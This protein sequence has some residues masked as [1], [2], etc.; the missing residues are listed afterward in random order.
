MSYSYTGDGT[1]SYGSF[2]AGRTGPNGT[3]TISGGIYADF[4]TLYA[5]VPQSVAPTVGAI[6]FEDGFN[7]TIA[8]PTSYYALAQVGVNNPNGYGALNVLSGSRFYSFR[9]V[10]LFGPSNGVNLLVGAGEDSTGQVTVDGNNAFFVASGVDSLVTIGR[11]GGDGTLTMSNNAIFQSFDLVVGSGSGPE[12]TTGLVEIQ[13]G[14]TIRLTDVDGRS[15]QFNNVNAG[16]SAVIGND[17]SGTG[18]LNI[19]GGGS[20]IIENANS[21]T[22][23]PRLSL[24]QNF[25]PSDAGTARGTATVAGEGSEIRLAQYGR[26][27]FSY[28]G[29]QP[30]FVVGD[31]GVGELT[32]SDNAQVNILGDGAQLVVA[33]G[34]PDSISEASSV[35]IQSGA[36][37]TVDSQN[38]GFEPGYY[39]SGG[40]SVTIAEAPGLDGLIEVTGEGSLLRVLGPDL[41]SDFSGGQISVGLVGNGQLTVSNGGAVE[42][43]MLN[44][45]Q[46]AAQLSLD[47]SY[48]N[49]LS[50]YQSSLFDNDPT[51]DPLVSSGEVLISSGG[52]VTLTATPARSYRGLNLAQVSGSEATVTVT[53]AGSTLTSTGGAGFGVIGDYGTGVLN[54]ED[55]GQVF[56]RNLVVSDRFGADGTLNVDGAGSRLVLS[57][58]FTDNVGFSTN[59]RLAIGQGEGSTGNVTVTNGGRIEISSDEE[60]IAPQLLVG[61]N[62]TGTLLIDGA[63]PDSGAASTVTLQQQGP[64]GYSYS[65]PEVIIGGFGF[66]DAASGTA[67]VQNG[68]QLTVYGASAELRIESSAGLQ[69]E[70]QILSGGDVLIDS[71]NYGYASAVVA[72]TQDSY[73]RILVD[74]EGSTLTVRSDTN[75]PGDYTTGQ[76]VLGASEGAVGVL[77]V[78]NGGAVNLTQ[79]NIGANFTGYLEGGIGRVTVSDGGSI[80]TTTKSETLYRGVQVG[81]NAGSRGFLTIDGAGSVVTSTG[82]PNPIGSDDGFP[83]D[84]VEGTGRVQIGDQGYGLSEVVNGG[85]LNGFFVE[86]GRR[87][88][89]EGRLVIDGSGSTLNVSNAYGQFDP[90]NYDPVGGFLRV[91]RDGGY[92]RVDVTNGGLVNVVNLPGSGADEPGVQIGRNVATNAVFNV[93]GTDG[94]GNASTLHVQMFGPGLETTEGEDFFGPF[95]ALGHS[96]GAGALNFLNRGQ[97]TVLGDGAA[98]LVGQGRD[99]G[100]TE[101]S[102]LSQLTIA[103]GSRLTV[104]SRQ[105]DSNAGDYTRAAEVSVGFNSSGRGELTVTGTGSVLEIISDNA[106]DTDAKGGTVLGAG[107]LVGR[108]GEGALSVLDGGLITINGGDD[109]FPFLSVGAGYARD[110]P[111]AEGYA[112]IS[113]Q[114]SEGNASRVQLYGTNTGV[115]LEE[116]FGAGGAISVGL[117]VGTRGELVIADGGQLI[118]SEAP[119]ITQ[120]GADTGSYGKVTVTGQGSLFATGSALRVGADTDFSNGDA[121]LDQ[122]GIGV[123][124]I[125]SGGLVTAAEAVIGD[126]GTLAIAGGLLEA[127]T[128][129]TG[130]LDPGGDGATGLAEITGDL[131]QSAGLIEI[132]IVD[133]GSFDQLVVN[134]NALIDPSAIRFDFSAI[135]AVAAGTRLSVIEAVGGTLG[136]DETLVDLSSAPQSFD[137]SLER[138]GD[139]VDLVFN[140]V[141]ATTVG[142]QGFAQTVGEGDPDN[143]GSFTFEFLRT[144]DLSQAFT[145][146]FAIEGVGEAPVDGADF[147]GGVLPSGQLVFAANAATAELVVTL[148]GDDLVE[149][150]EDF[151]L[152]IGNPVTAGASPTIVNEEVFATVLDDDAGQPG[153]LTLTGGALATPGYFASAGGNEGDSIT[154]NGGNYIFGD[155]DIGFHFGQN[156]GAPIAG[157]AV[158]ENGAVVFAQSPFTGGEAVLNVGVNFGG[159]EAYG[160][161]GI[162]GGSLFEA[163]SNTFRDN[164]LLYNTYRTVEIGINSGATGVVEV[165]GEGSTLLATGGGARIRVG[166]D[167]GQGTLRIVD[168]GY[169]G[170]FNIN[171]GRGS[172]DTETLGTVL[173]DG[174]GSTLRLSSRFGY[175]GDTYGGAGG[176]STFGREEGGNG[177]IVVSNG[178]QVLIDND[179]GNDD[180]A[181]LRFAR[182]YGSYGY[183]LVTGQGSRLVLEDF[184]DQD[185]VGYGT[186]ADL[187]I[188]DGGQG[189]LRVEDQ[190]Y[191]GVFGEFASITVADGR[192]NQ[193]TVE[194]SLLSV[195]GGSQVVV[196][197]RGYQGGFLNVGF[198]ANTNGR[199]EISG[200]GSTLTLRN[201]Q[202]DEREALEGNYGAYATIG[203]FGRGELLI[204]DGAR[205]VIDGADDTSVGLGVGTQTNEFGSGA[206]YVTV[207]GEGSAIDIIST[208][209][210]ESFTELF[211]QGGRIRIGAEFGTSDDIATIGEVTVSDGG[212]INNA[213]TDSALEIATAAGST[214]TLTVTG[215]GSVVNA[216][217][218][219]L[220]GANLDSFTGEVV[221]AAGQGTL[222]ISNNGEVNTGLTTIGEGGV[223]NIDGGTLNSD[224]E[225]VGAFNP[226]G[227]E[228]IGTA[229]V[230]G[231]FTQSLGQ[232]EVEVA[233]GRDVDFIDISGDAVI[234]PASIQ[235]DLSGLGQVSVGSTFPFLLVSGTLDLDVDQI[236]LSNIDIPAGF[237]V[238]VLRTGFTPPGEDAPIRNQVSLVVTEAPGGSVSI[239]GFEQA[240]VEGDAG[241]V[242]FT[243]TLERDDTAGPLSVDFAV[244][245]VGANPADGDDF[246][247][248]LLPS[249]TVNFAPGDRRAD[250][251]FEVAGDQ[252]IEQDE[253]FEVVLSSP[254]GGQ[255]PVSIANGSA[256]GR[257]IND[258]RPAT[259]SING[260]SSVL[261]EDD[262][263]S[264]FVTFTV[265]RSG[266][267]DEAVTVGYVV[268]ADGHGSNED[269]VADFE[270][271]VGGIP[272]GAQVILEAGETQATFTVE[273]AGDTIIEPREDFT[274]S[275]IGFSG[276]QNA[277]VFGNVTALGQII[278]D[279]GRPPV[280]PVGL[281]ADVFGDP[282]LVSL[283]GLGYDFQAVGEF[284]LVESSDPDAPLDVQIRTAPVEG[285]DLVSVITAVAFDLGDGVNGMIDLVGTPALSLDGLRTEVSSSGADPISAGASEIFFDG[286]TYT[287]VFGTGDAITVKLFDG[288]INVCVFLDPSHGADRPI[289]GLLGNANGVLSDDFSLRSGEPIPDD[290]LFIDEAGVPALD[291]DFLYGEYADS[292]RVQDAASDQVAFSRFFYSGEAGDM[293]TADYTDTSF[294]AGVLDV[295][296]LPDALVEQARAAVIA[297]GIDENDP[298][299]ES[300]LLDFALTGDDQFAAG[301]AGVVAEP[302]AATTPEAAPELPTTVGV[303]ANASVVEEGDEGATTVSFTFYR[304]GD[305]TDPLAVDYQ[306]AGDVDDTDFLGDPDLT[307]QVVFGASQETVTLSFDIAGDTMF[308]GD[309]ELRILLDGPDEVL[310]AAPFAITDIVDGESTPIALNDPEI[311]GALETSENAEMIIAA[312][313][314]L[315]NDVDP[316]GEDLEI[317]EVSAQ[318]SQGIVLSLVNGVITY[319]PL[320]AFDALADEEELTDTFIYTVSD[321]TGGTDTAMV[322]VTI[323]G[324]NDTAEITSSDT[325]TI[326]ENTTEVLTVTA[327]DIDGEIE[328]LAFSIEA[329]ESD[330]GALFTIDET[331]VL[332]FIAAP[333]FETPLDQ[334]GAPGDNFYEVTVGV[335]DGIDVTLQTIT[336]EVTDVEEVPE[337][338]LVEGSS[339]NDALIGTDGDDEFIGGAGRLD[340]YIGG[341]GADRFVFGAEATNG[342]REVDLILDFD[343]R[344]DTIVLRDGAVISR[345]ITSG[346]NTILLLD[347]GRDRVQ[348][349]GDGDPDELQVVVEEETLL[350]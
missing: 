294:P 54:I 132:E 262:G 305:A 144:G 286:E 250:L 83:D 220:L 285:S 107:L 99:Y 5:G 297:A 90:R 168:G 73:G 82:N 345:T 18:T 202:T 114:D 37:V 203:R 60:V 303:T 59:G 138:V 110:M 215:R 103:S 316:D 328:G 268:D 17:Q 343:Y 177:R 274:V 240:Q 207:T 2:D 179:F 10:D 270:D 249:S 339:G 79:L 42:G 14:G 160:R 230:N 47:G 197:G 278:N 81:D 314:L 139:R 284:T 295:E 176:Y 327:E 216:G 45:G 344:E 200:A 206:G 148:A 234:D 282:H 156:D 306:V 273:I 48:F 315:A 67:T 243:Y 219:L 223:L 100:F 329:L 11:D 19:S 170:T 236:D 337:I 165:S 330:D 134:G 70:L 135:G 237:A 93:D 332:K 172:G 29:G 260:F 36:V 281:E 98:V 290:V 271:F 96:G 335:S 69:S 137:L 140:S 289:T 65:R 101:T 72:I 333:D 247:G 225:S 75:V 111:S 218:Q 350:S 40:A 46:N 239:L 293:G 174:E 66:S 38:Y 292:W 311:E 44:V 205:L 320:D 9:Q 167:G 39:S 265:T 212:A 4:G 87:Q 85:T 16:A 323:I 246:V 187:L 193:G 245:G 31:G 63:N 227:D 159:E 214:G 78:Q 23:G 130:R 232:I 222:N 258:D 154:I 301:A 142:A 28:G 88:G 155:F 161:L 317:T 224:V 124:R 251:S 129:I 153:V 331:G 201:D 228:N 164:G 152:V 169:V 80:T 308:E 35:S 256:P 210:G 221:L 257:I 264:S 125:E 126:S 346:S 244:Q 41:Y 108:R 150:D 92:G 173:V 276:D 34:R 171:A 7:G 97:G 104:D 8:R 91:T 233:G 194:A 68:G 178:G 180:V 229:S 95:V 109:A 291:F 309:E 217:E 55:G 145:I 192:N 321:G 318:S 141:P 43:S 213:P 131:T 116:G 136:L 340:R 255:N 105:Q 238:D 226:G 190:S 324:E 76:L 188:G 283:D 53:G 300:A 94:D 1:I 162:T 149:A 341:D 298:N 242:V 151:R 127:T 118:N 275:L 20:L 77:D 186:G 122:G 263:A 64:G 175:Y 266:S 33:T 74:G 113:G 334:G 191:V 231:D 348:I 61:I 296:T 84:V 235:F 115:G 24:G 21:N 51:N 312:A 310:V 166:E 277:F 267:V 143:T 6:N 50:G 146:D 123:L 261:E 128:L 342:S 27:D 120:I 272:Q 56:G 208:A 322:T 248:G 52:K 189:V 30:R 26:T 338:N 25:G 13:S 102:N 259:I 326:Q 157:T 62:G 198:Q 199:L 299:F 119:S 3:L 336:V 147:V 12:G 279:D 49:F 117:R 22:S 112:L 86:V 307:G 106:A 211:P 252:L 184:G 182:D 181:Y 241:S 253:L 349:I 133:L 204:E 288:F 254:T 158:L 313:T 347:G 319:D 195:T 163:R 287:I 209:D 121:L 57:T 280:I 89:G 196:D 304:I 325:A 269:L 58:A 183:G 71:Q 32:V 302:E 185:P 15:N